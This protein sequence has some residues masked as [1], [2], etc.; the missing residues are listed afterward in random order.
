[1]NY[2]WNKLEYRQNKLLFMR[3]HTIC[4]RENNAAIPIFHWNS[5]VMNIDRYRMYRLMY[6]Q[7]SFGCDHR[8]PL[9]TDHLT[10]KEGLSWRGALWFFS[11]KIF[12]FPM[13]LKFFFWFWWRKKNNLIQ[14][15]CHITYQSLTSVPQLHLQNDNTL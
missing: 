15:F 1:M 11:K 7:L 12:W 2:L 10:C 3:I 8:D 14:S 13:L 9:G 6:I 5:I 4:M